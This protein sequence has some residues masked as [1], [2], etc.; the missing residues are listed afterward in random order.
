MSAECTGYYSADRLF[1]DGFSCPKPG[2]DSRAVFCCGFNDIKYCCEDPDS[3]FPYEYGYMWWLSIGALVGLSIAAVVLLAFL[4]TVCVLCYLFIAVKPSRLDNGLPLRAPG[5]R[6]NQEGTMGHLVSGALVLACLW[7]AIVS[8]ALP[9]TS[10]TQRK[11]MDE[12]YPAKNDTL[13]H[14]NSAEG[15]AT[16]GAQMKNYQAMSYLAAGLATAL[17]A[18]LLVVAAVKFRLFHRFLASYRHSLLL[19]AD[20]VS[21]Y[22][23]EGVT[24]PSG[25]GMDGR[26]GVISLEVEEDDDG[27]IEDNY[28]PTSDRQRAERQQQRRVEVDDSDEDLEEFTI[29]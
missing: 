5:S 6:Q 19:E 12:D 29:G 9:L 1:V 4:I 15:G 13:H 2:N 26:L 11:L 17:T 25:G 20:V 18:S 3:F 21:Q 24:Y 10:G 16:G 14:S 28:I 22:G 23:H 27:F 8:T 7:G